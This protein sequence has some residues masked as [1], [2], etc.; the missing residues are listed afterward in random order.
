V[1]AHDGD[2][3][4]GLLDYSTSRV[5]SRLERITMLARLLGPIGFARAL[6]V[7]YARL[8]VDTPVPPD[9]FFI[10]NVRV[11][12][13]QRGRG[14]G[15]QLMEWADQHARETGRPRMALQTFTNNPA[16]RLYE[17]MGFRVTDSRN[18]ALYQRYVGTGRCL[19]EKVL[20]A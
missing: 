16:M 5:T 15:A 3:V 10:A 8:R 6:P 2:S 17:R 20:D 1:I 12:E 13:C 11:D 14:I 19:M 7:V 9:A 4:V 18:H